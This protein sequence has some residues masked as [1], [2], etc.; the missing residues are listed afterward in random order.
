ME[1]R[2]IVK[3]IRISPT[4]VGIVADL[5]RGKP[6]DEALAILRFTP[7]KASTVVEKAIRSAVANAENNH[8]MS[9]DELYVSEIHVGPGPTLKRYHPRQRGQAFPILKRTS[10]LTVVLKEREEG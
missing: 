10:H 2:C 7:K 5:V 1:A 8:D 3:H 4:K 9:K 6:V